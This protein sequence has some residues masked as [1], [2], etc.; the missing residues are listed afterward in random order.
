MSDKAIPRHIATNAR[1]EYEMYKSLLQRV[2]QRESVKQAN[3]VMS[4]LFINSVSWYVF[5]IVWSSTNID[6]KLKSYKILGRRQFCEEMTGDI[7]LLTLYRQ[8]YTKHN[9]S[10]V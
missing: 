9:N 5:F 8:K 3:I 10:I 7:T 1:V 6:A 4:L 2:C